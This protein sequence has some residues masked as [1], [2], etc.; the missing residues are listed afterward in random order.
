MVHFICSVLQVKFFRNHDKSHKHSDMWLFFEKPEALATVDLHISQLTS[1]LCIC[2]P[3]FYRF[4]NGNAE[5]AK[6]QRQT[7][8]PCVPS[9]A[10]VHPSKTQPYHKHLITG[11]PVKPRSNSDN[12]AVFHTMVCAPRVMPGKNRVTKKFAEQKDF[13]KIIFEVQKIPGWKK[14]VTT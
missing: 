14:Y 10:T 1:F 3:D 9:L 12:N 2:L 4:L 13:Q 7:L 11:L 5:M 8:F 6:C